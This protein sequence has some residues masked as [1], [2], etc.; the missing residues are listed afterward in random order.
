MSEGMYIHTA[1]TGLNRAP[2]LVVSIFYFFVLYLISLLSSL[3]MF[4]GLLN[5]AS[6]VGTCANIY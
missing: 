4:L 6:L 5:I 1:L 3:S 2:Y